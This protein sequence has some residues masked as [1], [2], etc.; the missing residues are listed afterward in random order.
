VSMSHS[1]WPP[2]LSWG[3]FSSMRSREMRLLSSLFSIKHNVDLAGMGP[4]AVIAN[5]SNYKP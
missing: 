1:S 3:F 5:A 4:E 2:R